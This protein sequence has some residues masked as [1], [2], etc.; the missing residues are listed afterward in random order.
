MA[1]LI[2]KS[3]CDG[4]LPLTIGTVTLSE[5]TPAQIT[6]L[7]PFN[8]QDKAFSAALKAAHGMAAPAPGRSSGKATSRALWFGRGQWMLVGPAADA[9][10][11]DVAAVTD[12]SDAWAVVRLEGAGSEDV[13][14]RLVPADLRRATFPRGRTARTLVQHMSASVTRVG[15]NAFQIMVFRSMARTLVHELE[16]AMLGVNARVALGGS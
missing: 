16:T 2:A 15:E 4:L 3:P 10:L 9:S 12:Q 13:L 6:H 11:N 5:E 14:A 8:G 1:E 7:A